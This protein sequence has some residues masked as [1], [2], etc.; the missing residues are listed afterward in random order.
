MS[1]EEQN[2]FEENGGVLYCSVMVQ[3]YLMPDGTYTF[4][5]SLGA[6]DADVPLST[7]LGHLELA[8]LA[9]IEQAGGISDDD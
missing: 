8:K 5:T 7:Y 4:R 9:L 3:G 1:D 6:D 2:E